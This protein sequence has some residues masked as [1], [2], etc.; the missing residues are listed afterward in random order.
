MTI[1]QLIGDYDNPA[2]LGSR[3]RQRRSGPLREMIARVYRQKGAVSILDVG[4]RESYWNI[5]PA[6]FLREHRVRIVM[7]NLERDVFPIR[8]SDIFSTSVGDGCDLPYEDDSFD[9]C[10]SNS[11]IEHVNGWR[12]KVA[13]AR[14]ASR[15][16]PCYFHQTPNYWF[17]W[18]PHFGIPF[19]H[20]LPEP[21]RL[22][23][24]FRRSLGWHKP[25]ASVDDGMAIIEF[26]S[27]LTRAMVASLFPDAEIIGE[28]FG[29]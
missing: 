27:L 28:K 9:I 4:G 19:F 25:A 15:V 2:S 11:V 10:H 3:F 17:P 21:M 20:W 12:G 5:L 23:I 24:A 26:A 16:A 29:G 7:V 1:A 22:W 6:A 8:Q 18:E 13:F 14:E